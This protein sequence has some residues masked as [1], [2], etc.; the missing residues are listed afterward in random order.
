MST[1]ARLDR[2]HSTHPAD[3]SPQ[4]AAPEPA[5]NTLFDRLGGAP[6]IEAVVADLYHRLLRDPLLQPVFD[7]IDTAQLMQH[8]RRFL[9]F[10]LGGARRYTGRGLR[11][12]HAGVVE[13]HG[14]GRAHFDAV[15]G[16]LH[17]AM[18]GL[19]VAAALVEETVQVA[20]SVRADV[21]GE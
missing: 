13:R 18:H 10:A 11:E 2:R 4:A 3:R 12:A 21:L 6:A 8:Q 14:I 15:L 16:H 1:H 7:G 20:T 9:A 5:M 19:G 17:A